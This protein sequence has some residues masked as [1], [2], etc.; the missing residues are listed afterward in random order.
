MEALSPGASLPLRGSTVV[1]L[2]RFSDF[3]LEE[4]PLAFLLGISS[5]IR[6]CWVT[7]VDVRVAAQRERALSSE[8]CLVALS[9]ARGEGLSG[10]DSQSGVRIER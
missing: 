7:R 3:R 2:R 4:V 6:L 5:M 10:R 1:G 8:S 9:R